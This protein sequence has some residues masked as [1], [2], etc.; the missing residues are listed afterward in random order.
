M[1]GYADAV[2][3]QWVGPNSDSA[4]AL[5]LHAAVLQSRHDFSAALSE[6][7]RALRLRPDDPQAWLIRATVLRV[8]GRYEEASL[9]CRNLSGRVSV[10]VDTLCEQGMR[11]L[12]GKLTS[13][14]AALTDLPTHTMPAAE[15]AWRDSEL[16]EMAVRM[17]RDEAA[18]R[19]FKDGLA[20]APEDFYIRAA[21]ADLLLRQRRAND[22][23]VLLTGKENLE[24]LLLRIAIAQKQLHDPGLATSRA[25]LNAV[26]AAEHQRGEGLH[27]REEARFL[28]DVE[29]EA[30][31]ALIAAT[32]NWQV[33]HETDDVLVFVQAAN[34]SGS[35]QAAA[36]AL[37]FVRENG[38][39]DARLRNQDERL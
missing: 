31:A 30:R 37:V 5:I 6:L 39:E 12:T 1:L 7:D 27:R 32:D 4:D 25:R 8:L 26:F 10:A 17:G 14:Y 28:L 33:Q 13:A 18:E 20:S 34:A 11:G 36:A 38:L 24:P 15:R 23:L 9:A 2:L 3:A 19:W 35:P 16:G 29:G 21:Y 22:A